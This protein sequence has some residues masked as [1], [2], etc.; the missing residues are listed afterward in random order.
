[1]EFDGI[2]WRLIPLSG[3]RGAY[4]LAKAADGRI[5]VGSEGEVGMLAPD[6]NGSMRYVS[7][8]GD[9]PAAFRS[10]QDR[11]IQIVDTPIGQVYLTDHWLIVKPPSGALTALRS[12]DY[13][14]RTA[15]FNGAL[16]VLD[17]VQGL[18]R[19]ENG[20]QHGIPGGEGLRGLTMVVTKAGLL[21]PSF[22][23]GMVLYAPSA[24]NPWQTPHIQDWTVA[25]G[26]DVTSAIAIEGDLLALGTAQ[27]GLTLI[28]MKTGTLQRI[29]TAEGLGDAHVYSLYYDRAGSMW[30]ALDNGISLVSLNLP[31]DPTA[32]P[33]I[34]WV[35]SVV[36]TRDE[37]Q[38]FGGTYFAHADGVQQLPQGP[39]Q[40]LKF[41]FKY[42]AFRIDYSA[43]GLL[44][45]GHM[46]FQTYLKGV[47]TGWSTWSTRSERE[48]TELHPGKWNFEVRARKPTGEVSGEGSYR[49][50]ID[51]VWY[52]T[53]WFT[54]IQ[55][56]FVATLLVIS[57]HVKMSKRLEDGLTTF[58]VIVPFTYVSA[59]LS[60]TIGHYSSGVV[61]FKVLMSSLLSFL[62]DPAKKQLKKGVQTRKATVVAK[63]V[64]KVV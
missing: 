62:L 29:G 39:T 41:P 35:R 7:T 20:V 16:Y 9:L 64:E 38:V 46:E 40:L 48:F 58:S 14:L 49:F 45:T 54:V 34:A 33:F 63:K 15:W 32:R 19:L 24:S 8:V 56:A 60:S 44:A 12:D 1:L 4:A 17:G 11:V 61:F 6:Q 25:D 13:F 18:T 59:A 37:R 5:L 28:D 10:D 55:V 2:R 43:D 51:Q 3:G 53:W 47:D 27:H 26:V 31:K 21:I 22:N 23:E 52:E 42:N 57:S 50:E 36:G 30:L